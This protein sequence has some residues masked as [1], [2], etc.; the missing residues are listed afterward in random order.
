MRLDTISV[1]VNENNR[2]KADKPRVWVEK[3]YKDD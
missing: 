1:F 2:K 3:I